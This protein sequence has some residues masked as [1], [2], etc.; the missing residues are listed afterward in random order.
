MSLVALWWR[1]HWLKALASLAI[2]AG[3]VWLLNRGAL[4]VIPARTAFERMRWWT[5]PAYCVCLLG[6]HLARSG[7]WYWLLAPVRRMPLRDV[8]YAAFVGFFAILLLP[9]RTGEMAR[10]LL[11]RRE[12]ALSGWAAMGT[13]AAERILDGLTLSVILFVALVVAKPLDP[14]PDHIGNLPVP[15]AAVPSAARAAVVLFLVAFAVM[16]T[17][18]FARQRARRFILATIGRISEQLGLWVAARLEQLTEGFRFLPQARYTVPFA[19]VTLV[20][21]LGNAASAWLLAWGCGFHDITYSQACTVV[22]VVALGI[23]VPNAPGFFGAFQVSVYAALAMFYPARDVAGIGA[24]Y[25]LLIY[26]C[27]VGM[28][29]VVGTTALVLDR[30]NVRRALGSASLASLNEPPAPQLS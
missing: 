1:R 5:V 30:D 4:P 25:V 24:A 29:V 15:A 20:Y 7:R 13:V 9:F 28:T 22:G 17:F 21:W 26:T 16:T 18:Y 19:V 12:G 3:F 6:V 23:L 11:I 2:A 10:P 14:L 8:L 27:Q